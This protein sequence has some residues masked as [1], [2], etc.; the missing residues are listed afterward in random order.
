MEYAYELRGNEQLWVPPPRRE[1]YALLDSAHHPFHQHAHVECFLILRAGRI[2]GRV[3]MIEN[4]A[5]NA[6]SGERAGHFGFL[7]AEND[8][9]VFR[10]IV[11]LAARW[12]RARGL[13]VLRGPCSFSTNEECGVLVQGFQCEP[14][15]MTPH[16][17]P[18]YAAHLEAAG[19]AKARDLISYHCD[20]VLWTER[21]PALAERLRE[22]NAR[23]GH[24]VR[25][26]PIDMDHFDREV[27]LIKTVYN[28]AWG[29]NWGFVP[30]TDAE[31]D[32]M[33]K[34][35]KPVIAPFMVYFAECDGEV[36]GFLLGLP[37]YNV[38]LR[39][40]G[41]RLGPIEV[42]LFFLL[43]RNIHRIRLM[44]MGVVEKFRA[45]GLE[46]LMIAE[47]AN[48]CLARGYTEGELGW[49]LEDNKVMNRGILAT[50]AKVSRVHRLYEMRLGGQE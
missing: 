36:A 38:V 7:E 45:R 15:I 26:R 46:T 17:P 31:I 40:L 19:M 16:T 49:V 23:R 34:D 41:G 20:K 29:K 11:R 1:Q 5:H 25:I 37:D 30:M 3:A 42:L 18:Y 43:K 10:A 2:A 24:D 32:R 13:D 47:F 28:S 33:A 48:A 14:A 27:G 12:C 4:H 6:H 22:K 35:L 8:P 39:H 21:I 9:A 50:G 44:G